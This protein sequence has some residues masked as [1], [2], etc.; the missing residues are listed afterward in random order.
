MQ[1]PIYKRLH[2]QL[3]G[4]YVL[5]SGMTSIA[6]VVVGTWLCYKSITDSINKN[7]EELIASNLTQIALKGDQPYF[8]FAGEKV[9]ND[10]AHQQSTVQL[11]NAQG[12][13]LEEFGAPGINKLEL[14][15]DYFEVRVGDREVRGTCDPIK[16]RGRIVGYLQAEIPVGL[17]NKATLEFA[18]TMAEIMPLLLIALALCGYF[19]SIKAGKPVEHAFNLLKQFMA[20]A[21][22]ELRTPVHAIQ[23]MAENVAAEAGED[24]QLVKDM[25]GIS[26]STDRMARLIDDMMMLTKIEVQQ[27]PL[28]RSAVRLDQL[29]NHAVGELKQDFIDKQIAL[30]VDTLDPIT[31]EGDEHALHRVFSNLLGNA[32]RYTDG[33]TVSVRMNRSKNLVRVVVRDTGIGIDSQSLPHL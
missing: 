21:S 12:K 28:Q 31:V 14:H 16:I 17:R 11:Y 30:E 3:T 10:W 20:D 6:L 25:E 32:L 22:H 18:M 19:L 29:I 2:L 13:L 4:W 7:I 33:G 5:L 26:K 15:Q 8:I 1:Q 9:S 24:S 27:L 23:L